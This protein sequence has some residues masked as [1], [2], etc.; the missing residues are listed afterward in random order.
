MHSQLATLPLAAGESLAAHPHHGLPLHSLLHHR[1][2]HYPSFYL[3]LYRPHYLSLHPM[4]EAGK[5]HLL[6]DTM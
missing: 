1:Y 3:Y 4:R 2:R 5:S 6:S